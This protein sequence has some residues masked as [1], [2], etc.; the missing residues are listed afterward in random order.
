MH[1]WSICSGFPAHAGMDPRWPRAVPESCG[2]PR[3]R[4]DGP[5][6]CGTACSLTR[7]S[8]HTR[9]WTLATLRASVQSGGFPAHAGMDPC[10]SRR[11]GSRSGLPRTRG[12]GPS[13]AAIV[14]TTR[15]A[16]PHTRGW[17]R[18]HRPDPST[19]PGF[20]AHAGMD[21]PRAVRR[22]SSRR[23]PRTRGDGPWACEGASTP[24]Q[25]SPHTRGW[26]RRD[27]RATGRGEGFPAH[28]GM[29]LRRIA[30]SRDLAGLPRTRGDGPVTSGS[31]ERVAE[32]SPH[33]RGWTSCAR[34]VRAAPVGFPAHAGMDRNPDPR[35]VAPHG[36]PRTRGDNA[37]NARS[38]HDGCAAET[39]SRK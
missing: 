9:G 20:P 31:R 38:A 5:S 25:A 32:A 26:T 14:P 13:W 15:P 4:G 21:P 3:T 34:A 30:V 16:S 23:L 19:G 18:R 2:L 6:P 35:A 36:L 7:A 11:P 10:A 33:T 17:T 39:Y 22:R 28:A 8:P 24:E 1:P 29:D 12:D 37:G 27:G